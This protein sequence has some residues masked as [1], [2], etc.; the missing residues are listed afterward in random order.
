M[1]SS[2]SPA[3]IQLN[4]DRLV[5]DG[6]NLNPRERQQLQSSIEAELGRLLGEQGLH[7]GLVQ[8][9]AVPK[10]TAAPVQ[11]SAAPEQLGRQIAASVYGGIG[12]GPAKP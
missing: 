1:T 5:L 4:I 6:V 7:A 8:G 11:M 12:N 9:L 10:L 3:N 2:A